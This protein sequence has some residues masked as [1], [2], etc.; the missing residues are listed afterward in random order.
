MV[1]PS[2]DTE[3]FGTNSGD[4]ENVYF[5]ILYDFTK[6][7]ICKKYINKTPKSKIITSI[8]SSAAKPH[9]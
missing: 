5:L 3:E 8:N 1:I 2:Y 7:L 4:I 6:H 9:P